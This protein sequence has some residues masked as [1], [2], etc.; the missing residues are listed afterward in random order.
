M[1]IAPITGTLTI[2]GVAVPFTGSAVV[3]DPITPAPP[4]TAAAVAAAPGFAAAVAALL[5]PAP[6]VSTPPPVVTPPVTGVENVFRA[7][8]FYWGGDWSASATPNYNDTTVPAPDGTP[9]LLVTTQ[10][11]GLWQPYKNA[12]CQQTVGLCFDTTPYKYLNFSIKPRVTNQVI[13]VGFMSSGDTADGPVVIASPYGA[14]SGNPPL[15]QW[16][17]YKMPLSAFKL[18]DTTVLKFWV[19]D[20]T[21]LA[22]NAWNL[23]DVY[24]SAT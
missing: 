16:S 22:S 13:Q 2:D 15:G 24:F 10:K 11:W 3:P 17:T 7:G 9:S 5:V 8:K 4:P 6:P 14:S 18:T 23:A 21:G 1:A 19:Q 20:Q 12:G